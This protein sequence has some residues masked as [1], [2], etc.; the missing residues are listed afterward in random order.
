MK[1]FGHQIALAV[2]GTVIL[3]STAGMAQSVPTLQQEMPYAQARQILLDEGW[4]AIDIP[5]LQRDYELS[6][7]EDYIANELGYGE[8]ASCAGTGLGLCRFEFA[9]ADGRKLIVVTANNEQEPTLY[10][11]WIEW[12]LDDEPISLA[13]ELD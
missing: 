10:R 3:Q 9:A 4:Q 11:W 5:A 7:L 13:V 12:V 1:Q 6:G 2:L 8:M